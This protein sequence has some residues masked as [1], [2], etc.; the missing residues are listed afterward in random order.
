MTATRPQL[1]Y[2]AAGVD[3]A[4]DSLLRGRPIVLVPDRG[5]LRAAHVVFA[6]AM[7]RAPEISA[8]LRIA[9]ATPRVALTPLA[10]RR[11]GL[12]A[13][14]AHGGWAPVH[15]RSGERLLVPVEASHGVST[16]VSAADRARTIAVLA[17]RRSGPDDVAMP[18]HIAVVSAAIGEPTASGAALALTALAGGPCCAVLCP[19]I[20]HDGGLANEVELGRVA[21]CLGAPLVAEAEALTSVAMT[22]EECAGARWTP[23]VLEGGTT[24]SRGTLVRPLQ[25][26]L[27]DLQRKA[28]G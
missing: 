19:V 15:R 16:G 8:M 9:C 20:G 22:S 12:R 18:G 17:D 6:A 4:V 5:A 21:E 11:L 25:P 14:R 10:C 3:F 7:V 23:T 13:Q 24:L 2:E 28:L 27:V 1:R 26:E